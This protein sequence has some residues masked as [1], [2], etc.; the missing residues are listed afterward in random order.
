VLPPVE[1]P[2]VEP[3]LVEPPLVEPPVVPSIDPSLSPPLSDVNASP[4]QYAPATARDKIPSKPPIRT[5]IQA[6]QPGR[7]R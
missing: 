5:V 6:P 4:P 3:P 2:L 7:V 1:P